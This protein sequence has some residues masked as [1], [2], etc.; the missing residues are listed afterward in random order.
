MSKPDILMTPPLL[1]LIKAELAPVAGQL[2]EQYT[3]DYVADAMFAAIGEEALAQATD[4]E[5]KQLQKDWLARF[6]FF[7]T[8]VPIPDELSERCFGPDAKS[9]LTA[10]GEAVRIYGEAAVLAEAKRRG[11]ATLTELKPQ[12]GPGKA[13]DKKADTTDRK[14]N[15]WSDQMDFR[16]PEER[17][18][19]QISIIKTSAK[20]AGDLARAAGKTISNQPLRK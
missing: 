18:A 1:Q 4:K 20:M 17:L 8:E 7:K 14:N 10:R 6:E 2:H 13:A 19:K 5:R 15:P 11:F 16:T 3:V 9:A 12:P